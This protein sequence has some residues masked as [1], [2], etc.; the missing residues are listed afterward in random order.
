MD[1]E[2]ISNLRTIEGI[3]EE[4]SNLSCGGYKRQFV[5]KYGKLFT[6]GDG[7]L[8]LVEQNLD[9]LSPKLVKE[10]ECQGFLIF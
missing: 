8:G 1:L 10:Y 5:V 7:Q 4:I 6:F 9:A 2:V 3:S